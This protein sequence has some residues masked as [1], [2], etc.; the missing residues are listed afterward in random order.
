VKQI[1]TSVRKNNFFIFSNDR[2]LSA[3]FSL[4]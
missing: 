3:E 2:E 4:V 1:K